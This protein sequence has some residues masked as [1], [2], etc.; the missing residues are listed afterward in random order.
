[1]QVTGFS[2][3]S[4]RFWC[5]SK[6][7]HK[8]FE[9]Q[10]DGIISIPSTWTTLFTNTLKTQHYNLVHK[11]DEH[12]NLPLKT[13]HQRSWW[14]S[15]DGLVPP[16]ETMSRRE[17]VRGHPKRE[18]QTQAYLLFHFIYLHCNWKNCTDIHHE[19]MTDWPVLQMNWCATG[20]AWEHPRGI[21]RQAHLLLQAHHWTELCV[22]KHHFR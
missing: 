17:K 1:M 7:I 8:R 14:L 5:K 4:G 3:W 16:Q 9:H 15:A 12:D 10:Q 19:S 13:G 11:K 20:R 6:R 21:Q 18:S 2:S 22:Q